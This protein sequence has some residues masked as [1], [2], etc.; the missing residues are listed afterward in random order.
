MMPWPSC[1]YSAERMFTT[2]IRKAVYLT[3]TNA[4]AAI[5]GALERYKERGITYVCPCKM[6]SDKE[7]HAFGR[8]RNMAGT[9]YW[10]EARQFFQAEALIRTIVLVKLSGYTFQD[11][12]E[13]M[14][15]VREAQ[16][17]NDHQLAHELAEKI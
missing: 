7:E 10:T 1:G 13:H 16:K 12:K 11:V 2:D 8:R 14:Q 5:T 9:N 4:S 15:P 3:S 17:S 6:T